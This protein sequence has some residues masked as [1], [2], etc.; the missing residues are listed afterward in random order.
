MK[1]GKMLVRASLL[2]A[3]CFVATW[4]VQIPVPPGYVN[5]G[6]CVVLL[7]GLVMALRGDLNING[8]SP[9]PAATQT[10][11]NGMEL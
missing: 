7:A 4:I 8:V 10:I 5:F 6:D 3:M 9:K 2:A 1:N 11:E